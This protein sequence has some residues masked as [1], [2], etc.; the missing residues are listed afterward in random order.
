M[1]EPRD[2]FL[3]AYVTRTVKDAITAQA[4]R[5]GLSV[6]LMV[7]SLLARGLRVPVGS[8]VGPRPGR[9]RKRATRGTLPPAFRAAILA[10]QQTR[11]ALA[12]ASGFTP[13]GLSNVL[14]DGS[15]V[16]SSKNVL[17]LEELARSVSYQG[18][19]ISPVQ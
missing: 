1:I 8:L 16:A 14:R 19:I 17:R 7:Q 18:R 2:Q 11:T 6:S 10:S 13:Q 15:F 9:G 3:G 5:R 4:E 12:K